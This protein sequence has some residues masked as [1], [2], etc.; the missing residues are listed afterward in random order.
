MKRYKT[1]MN[2]KLAL[3]YGNSPDDIKS[4]ADDGAEITEYND[5]SYMSFIEQI[6]NNGVFLGY[7]YK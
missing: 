2:G 7:D 4:L 1:M 5:N 3:F 6:K